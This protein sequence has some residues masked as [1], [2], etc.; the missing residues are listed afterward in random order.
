MWLRVTTIGILLAALFVP[1]RI[2]VTVTSRMSS[3]VL[4][5]FDGGEWRELGPGEAVTVPVTRWRWD[6]FEWRRGDPRDRIETSVPVRMPLSDM[7]LHAG[8]AYVLL[9]SGVGGYGA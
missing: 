8:S 9:E 2:A 4:L 1:P 3:P 6:A 7:L 5:R